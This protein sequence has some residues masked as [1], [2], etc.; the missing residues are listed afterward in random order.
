MRQY[1]YYVHRRILMKTISERGHEWIQ[2]QRRKIIGAMFGAMI[3]LMLVMYGHIGG[4]ALAGDQP[5]AKPEITC[6]YTGDVAA[7]A[8]GRELFYRNCAECHGDGDGG[9]G[10]DLTDNEWY[11]GGSDY[12]IFSTVSSGRPGGMPSWSG[13][14]KDDEIWKI[15]AFIRSI[16]KK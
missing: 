1:I 8:K 6:P 9:S 7:I 10:P 12:Q 14:L 3:A 15:I 2:K 16:K 4:T 11:C 5:P 13:E